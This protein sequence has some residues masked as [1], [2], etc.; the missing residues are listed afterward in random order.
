MRIVPALLIVLAAAPAAADALAPTGTL[1]AAFLAG[2]PVQGR[3]D[4]GTGAVSGPAPEL[5]AELARRRDVKFTIMPLAGTRAVLDAVKSDAADIGF[6]AFDPARAAEV[7][8]SQTYS[9]AHNTYIVPVASPIRALADIDRPG[10]V[11]GVGQGD[12]GDLH[13]TRTLK[14]AE[15][16][17]NPGGSLDEA[18]RLL[19]TGEI[20][21][22]AAN[23]QRLSEAVARMP[24]LRVLD[25]NFYAV[26][27][28][29]IVPRG[30]AA[31]RAIVDSFLDDTR[32]SGF[33]RAALD[34]ARLVGVDVAPPNKR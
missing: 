3:V 21:A 31:R 7:D 19:E 23:R 6:L 15:L 30:N 20:A 16:K 28:A 9:L 2:N 8:F 13:L 12:A 29:I 32:A 34:R 22:Y 5:V 14:S 26:E 25:E 24:G 1:R 4:A 33:I 11:V 10:R 27:Q 18:R 17:R